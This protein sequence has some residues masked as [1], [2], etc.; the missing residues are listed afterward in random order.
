MRVFVAGGTGV[1]GKFLVPLLVETGHEVVGLA[2]SVQKGKAVE[3]MGA[4]AVVADALNKEQLT[5]AIR[6]AEPEVIIHQLTAL[7]GVGNFKRLDEE[8][9]LTNRFRTNVTDTM[10]EAACSVRTR[11]FIAQSFCGW[12]F[13]REGGPVKTEE[14]P[15]DPN[16]PAS[17][18]KTLAA[19]EYLEDKVRKTADVQALALRYGFFYGPGTSISKDGMV[20]DLVR[21]RRLP[22][23]GDGAGIWSFIHIS[24]WLAPQWRPLPMAS[25][26]YTTSSMTSQRLS[27][28]GCRRLRRLWEPSRPTGCPS[29]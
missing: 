17:L 20:V 29:G 26:A 10:L 22:I 23:V 18:S 7:T 24:D 1:V 4:K 9:A 5:D 2:R 14:D 28:C 16:P 3:A 13:A 19:I 25:R 21:R 27:Q 6:R 15:L 8:F 12:P 11:R